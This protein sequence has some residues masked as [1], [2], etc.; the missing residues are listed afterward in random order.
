MFFALLV[1][2]LVFGFTA[3]ALAATYYVDPAGNNAAD[4]SSAT[5]WLTIQYAI[6]T[7][8]A[9]DEIEVLAGTYAED[10]VITEDN[11]EIRA[12]TGAAAQETL[13]SL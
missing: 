8:L 11:L 7:A 1:L 4:G 6:N 13:D 5:P 9:G 12:A 10:L 3:N 2:G